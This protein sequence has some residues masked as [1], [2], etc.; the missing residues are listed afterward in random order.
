MLVAFAI[1]QIIVLYVIM[2]TEN[3]CWLGIA[4]VHSQCTKKVV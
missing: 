4:L 2:F 1:C 3:Y